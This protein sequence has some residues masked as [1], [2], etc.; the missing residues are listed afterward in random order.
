M[1]ALAGTSG[2]E[3]FDTIVIGAGQA[4]PGLA[5]FLAGDGQRVALIEADKV[6]GT[7]LNRGCRPT[8][9]LRASARVAH[10][11][12]TAGKHGV[13]TGDVSVDFAAV[14]ARKD[15]M[16]DGWVSGFAEY[17]GGVERLE[18]IRGEGRF[19]GT[20]D[21][22]HHVAVGERVLAAP[23]VI[24]NVGT[25]ATV[26]PTP[27]L[28]PALGDVVPYLDNDSVLHLDALPRHLVILGGSYI[29]LELGQLFRRLGSEVTIIERGPRVAG[30][31]DPEISAEIARFFAAEGVTL[32]TDVGVTRVETVDG[33][34]RVVTADGDDVGG[35]HLLVAVG[36][37]PNTDTLALDTI[38]LATD[39]RGFVATDGSFHTAVHGVWT[40]GD[41]NGRG[42]FTHTSYQDHEILVDH[43]R[44]GARSADGRIPTYAMFTDPPLGRVGFNDREARASGRRVLKAS[45]PASRITRAV[46]DGETDGLV[47][48]L[49]DA[50]S[51]QLLGA[52]VLC[53]SGDEIVQI[54][55]A[56]MH[57]GASYRVLAD[58]L[59]IHPTMAEFYPTIL[60]SLTP[61]T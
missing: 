20:V 56:L 18:L 50:D 43:L 29:G 42:A 25:R 45:F 21:G 34:V 40:L 47:N 23:A 37:T 36:R 19:T 32:R 60:K 51:E 7:C 17:L 39:D 59:P 8:K 44:G 15:E 27:G 41:V 38:G 33:G 6:G 16:I 11:A 35:T 30:R 14:I 4:G 1:D 13:D 28:D 52:S 55:S 2:I 22:R 46:L 57:A 12:R 53:L 3:Q 31:E 54:V 10:L 26:P 9:A 49:V 58:M 48:V 61:L 24:L 5:T